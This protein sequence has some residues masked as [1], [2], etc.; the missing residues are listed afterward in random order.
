MGLATERLIVPIS[1]EDKRMVSAKAARL[2]KLSTAEFVRRAVLAYEP[3]DLETEAELKALLA[4]FPGLHAE[5]MAQLDLTD[6]ALDR[7]L[8]QIDSRTAA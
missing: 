3:E 4:A 1:A 6:A 5:T 2:G 8:A 7:C